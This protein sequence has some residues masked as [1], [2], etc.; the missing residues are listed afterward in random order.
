MTG[1]TH[2]IIGA[3]TAVA[4][5]RYTN[6]PDMM[7]IGMAVSGGI[8]G[9]LPDIDVLARK[10]CLGW[11]V[12]FIVGH[13][14][15]THSLIAIAAVIVAALTF[16]HPLAFGAA[17]GYVSHIAADMMT[18]RGVPLLY[19]VKTKYHLLPRQML[20][21]TGGTYETTIQVT[22]LFFIIFETNLRITNFPT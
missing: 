11:L 22:L 2:I 18:K 21:T 8:A 20:L 19:P 14:G 15:I 13:R 17:A 5:A 3:A 16:D 1:K 10:V 12:R 4:L 6:Q 9:L 7:V